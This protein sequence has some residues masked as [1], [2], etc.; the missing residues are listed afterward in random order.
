MS[1]ALV[2]VLLTGSLNYEDFQTALA[3]AT[4]DNVRDTITRT[5]EKRKEIV[6]RQSL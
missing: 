1:F 6:L 4:I 5:S 2:D 3:I